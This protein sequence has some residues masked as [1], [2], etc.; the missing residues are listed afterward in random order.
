MKPRRHNLL[1]EGHVYVV[2][3]DLKSHFDAIPK[4]RLLDI[5]KQKISDNAV[6]QL[7]KKYLDQEIMSELSKK[8]K[9]LSAQL[10]ALPP[11]NL[12]R[13]VQKVRSDA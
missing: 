11:I 7:V 10:S 1:K 4:D 2:D 8:A 3:A 5:V 12:G 13:R 6:L 9:D